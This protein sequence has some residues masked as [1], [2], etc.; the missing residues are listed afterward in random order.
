LETSH[1]KPYSEN[2]PHS[3]N[4][5]L[6]L[7]SDLHTLY[8]RG[9]LTITTDNKVVV[10]RRIKEDYGNGREYYKMHGKDLLVLPESYEEQPS[11]KY[12]E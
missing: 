12:I 10:S 6:L 1:I 5:G 11:K 9:Y 8:D 4:N 3:L 7:R 2:G